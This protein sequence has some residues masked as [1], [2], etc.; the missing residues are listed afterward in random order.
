MTGKV[1]IIRTDYELEC[2]NLDR[3]LRA[4]GAD[5]VLLPDNISEVDLI[6]QTRD[7]D[8]ILMCYTPITA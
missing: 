5:L 6:A 7:A 1:K 2:P 8:L 4:T 3:A